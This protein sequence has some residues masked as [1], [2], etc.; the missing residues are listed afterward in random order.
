MLLTIGIPL[1]VVA[2]AAGVVLAWLVLR[3]GNDDTVTVYDSATGD[4][5][6]VEVGTDN[7]M[8]TQRESYVIAW[9][10][11]SGGD[12]VLADLSGR[13]QVLGDSDDL[14]R[15]LP[16]GWLWRTGRPLAV[17]QPSTPEAPTSVL[18]GVSGRLIEITAPMVT[19]STAVVS[20]SGQFV[21]LASG[22]SDSVIVDVHNG[23]S[24]TVRGSAVAAS[25]E[26]VVLHGDDGFSFVDPASG[27]D[28]PVAVGDVEEWAVVAL[29]SGVVYVDP[30]GTVWHSGLDGSGPAEYATVEFA[31]QVE[32]MTI[33]DQVVVETDRGVWIIDRGGR[34]IAEFPT[35]TEVL[36]SPAT[37]ERS[38]STL[39]CLPLLTADE[40]LFVDP[41][42]GTV[43]HRAEFADTDDQLNEGTS[44]RLS[45]D[46]CSAALQLSRGRWLVSNPVASAT[47]QGE[48]HSISDDGLAAIVSNDGR[49]GVIE[50]S[51]PDTVVVSAD[52]LVFTDA[53]SSW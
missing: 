5:S 17:L 15:M 10:V 38:A 31:E 39:S 8:L 16:V 26:V 48:V 24:T 42:E 7:P 46:G 28:R 12:I 47:L 50:I 2:I 44:Q 34:A 19:S 21:V 49:L 27:D 52:R 25:D 20:R 35:G 53:G 29:D 32:L 45:S 3:S 6:D 4:T 36:Q 11:D 40:L 13:R 41:V 14:N 43:L 18:D 1:V 33:G 37:M 22:P 23:T 51:N 9:S 30:S